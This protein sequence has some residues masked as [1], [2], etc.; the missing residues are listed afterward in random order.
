MVGKGGQGPRDSR[1]NLRRRKNTIFLDE[2]L[3]MEDKISLEI[4][5][6]R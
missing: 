5:E 2:F 4:N 6:D 1:G 3:D